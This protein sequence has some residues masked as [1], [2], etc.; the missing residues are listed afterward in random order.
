MMNDCQYCEEFERGYLDLNGKSLGNRILLETDNFVV[1]PTLGQIVEGYLLIAPKKHYLAIGEIPRANYKELEEVQGK[2]KTILSETYGSPLFFEH[3]A[4]SRKKRGGCCIEH[5]HIHAV[6]VQVEILGDL[7]K[8]FGHKKIRDYNGL[9]TKFER[10]EPYFFLEDNFGRKY[11]FDIPDVVPS[12]YIRR[13]ISEKIGKQERWDWRSQPGLE[14]L[15]NT[16]RKLKGKFDA[17]IKLNKVT[18]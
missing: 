14:E 6:P 7:S 17:K 4:T 8:V 16:L 12:Q 11:S 15:E 9:K 18:K 13:I 10:E 3:G 5:A 2:V 1:F